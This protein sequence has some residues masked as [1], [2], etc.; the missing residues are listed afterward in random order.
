[1]Y[2]KDTSF[3]VQEASEG[4]FRR[5]PGLSRIGALSTR[6]WAGEKSPA[7]GRAVFCVW[8]HYMGCVKYMRRVKGAGIF[9]SGAKGSIR[10]LVDVADGLQALLGF[11][12]YQRNF[13]L[14]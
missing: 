1:M 2:L 8:F 5:A 13:G 6:R 9:I 10:G 7:G 12:Y 14:G 11:F 3:L 4:A